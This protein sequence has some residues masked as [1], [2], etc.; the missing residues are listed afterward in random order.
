MSYER[1]HIDCCKRKKRAK[2]TINLKNYEQDNIQIIMGYQFT[3]ICISRC[4]ICVI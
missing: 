4:V 2:C 1:L 3:C